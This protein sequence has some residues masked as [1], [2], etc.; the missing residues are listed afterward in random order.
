MCTKKKITNE[1]T[2][3][4]GIDICAQRSYCVFV[5]DCSKITQIGCIKILTIFPLCLY[6]YYYYYAL[7]EPRS[8]K[9]TSNTTTC[10]SAARFPYNNFTGTDVIAEAF[11]ARKLLLGSLMDRNIES[12][13][14]VFIF[15]LWPTDIIITADTSV[16][17]TRVYRKL[18][19]VWCTFFFSYFFAAQYFE[20]AWI[21]TVNE[22]TWFA[23]SLAFN[24]G[25]R[26]RTH[27]N[28]GG[29]PWPMMYPSAC[30]GMK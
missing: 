3:T 4:I 7:Y 16:R 23:L 13:L 15:V 19:P 10:C 29:V 30:Q 26:K 25:L 9:I 28:V 17:I 27:N 14:L 5:F 11:F 18:F 2:S 21:K 12:C 24:W 20:D 22:M 1:Q 6:Y 8:Y